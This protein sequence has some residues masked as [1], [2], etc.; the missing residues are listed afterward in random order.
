MRVHTP[1]SSL[2]APLNPILKSKC[3]VANVSM[4]R[5]VHVSAADCGSK[6]R[7]SDPL[8]RELKVVVGYLMW[9]LGTALCSSVL[10]TAEPS[11]P[12]LSTLS[13]YPVSIH[14]IIAVTTVEKLRTM[15]NSCS[16]DVSK[17]CP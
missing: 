3:D 6:K 5:Y 10:L 1:H 15:K 2:F 16:I 13:I 4:D 9:V 12:I 14:V 8:E 7:T 17:N 11:Y